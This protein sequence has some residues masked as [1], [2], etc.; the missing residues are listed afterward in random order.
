MHQE[1]IGIIGAGGSGREILPLAM[2]LENNLTK[3]IFV[4]DKYANQS[5]NG[6]DCMSESDFLKLKI[7]RKKFNIGIGSGQ[8]RF[9][10]AQRFLREN[11]TPISIISSNFITYESNI[12]GDGAVLCS[13]TLI[14]TNVKVGKFFQLNYFSYV[15]HDCIIGDFVTF[16]PRVSCNG[17]VEIGDFA[18]IGAGAVIKQGTSSKPLR[19]GEGAVIGMGAIVTKDVPP[20]T[21]VVGNPAREVYSN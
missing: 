13:N 19:I 20:F 11:V 21:T 3:L 6:Y 10:V 9:K 2:H 18:Y 15:A 8:V 16:A 17:N 5:I 14:T 4:D 12:I 1:I 7:P